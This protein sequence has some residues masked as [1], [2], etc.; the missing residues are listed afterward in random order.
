MLPSASTTA[1]EV[2]LLVYT[3]PLL[4]PV[5]SFK[6]P[7]PIV[8]VTVNCRDSPAAKVTV[9]GAADMLLISVAGFLPTVTV[10]VDWRIP[11]LAVI[12]T[13]PKVALEG[14]VTLPS[15]STS[16]RAGILLV[17]TVP[18]LLAVTSFRLPSPMVALTNSCFASPGAKVIVPGVTV[19]LFISVAGSFPTV[20]VTVAWEIPFLTV[21][22][23]VPKVALAGIEIRPSAS[24]KARA[25][26]LLV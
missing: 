6:L 3:V 13:V 26:L 17:Y 25:V 1:R 23:T 2:L 22:V 16:A 9:P 12:T 18:L 4:L 20:T 24:T 15:V 19:I 14:I 10:T 8:A 11:F 21:I 5:T 7:S